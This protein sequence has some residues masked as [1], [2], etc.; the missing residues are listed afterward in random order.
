MEVLKFITIH[1]DNMAELISFLL[2]VWAYPYLR[3]PYTK[4]LPVFLGF[5]F[6]SETATNL[7]PVGFHVTYLSLAIQAVYY[8][9]IFYELA[10]TRKIRISILV[11]VIGIVLAYSFSYIFL[12]TTRWYMFNFMRITMIFDLILTIIALNYLYRWSL[13]DANIFFVQEPS[14]WIAFGV[15]IFFSGYNIAVALYPYIIKQN[16]NVFGLRLYNLIPRLLSVVLY[17]CFSVAIVL[18]RRREL[19]VMNNSP[20]ECAY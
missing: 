19:A 3:L 20:G 5:I 18:Y 8:G 9:Y 16:L 15:V 6:V 4:W 12:D 14:V 7:A 11:F 17:S 13:L 2:A 1:A 10:S